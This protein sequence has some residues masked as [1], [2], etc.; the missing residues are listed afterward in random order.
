MQKMHSLT[1]ANADEL[2]T[3][4]AASTVANAVDTIATATDS[5]VPDTSNAAAT[6]P[7]DTTS[8]EAP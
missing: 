2:D 3:I 4:A 8:P 7:K 5:D 6:N 1:P